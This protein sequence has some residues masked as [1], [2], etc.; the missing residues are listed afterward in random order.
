MG[1][2]CGWFV[3]VC[4]TH[5]FSP[6][7]RPEAQHHKYKRSRPLSRVIQ[8]GKYRAPQAS[9][10]SFSRRNENG[11]ARASSLWADFAQH[12]LRSGYNIAR[13]RA[14]QCAVNLGKGRCATRRNNPKK[15]K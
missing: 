2:F 3:R 8:L 1:M 9:P 10:V 14:L 15:S 7:K 4:A 13:R 12:Q 11:G 6:I 5:F